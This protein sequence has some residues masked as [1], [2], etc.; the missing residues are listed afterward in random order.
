MK[1]VKKYEMSNVKTLLH[2]TQRRVKE[3]EE[4]AKTFKVT[5]RDED[6]LEATNT[7]DTTNVEKDSRDYY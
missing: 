6:S 1:R 2:E 5:Y 7:F 3:L 4:E